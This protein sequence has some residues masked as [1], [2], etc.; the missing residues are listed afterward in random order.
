MGLKFSNFGKA[1]IAS[2]PV[3]ATGRSF[4]VEPGKG[5]VFPALGAGDYFYGIFK[6]ASGNREIVKIEARSTDSFTIAVGG[7]GLDGTTPRTWAAGDYFVATLTNI[8]LQETL[9]NENL[10]ALGALVSSADKMPYFT[11]AGAAALAT[12][13]PFARALL[14]DADAAAMRATLGVPA[15]NQVI[16]AGTAMIF[17]QA[18]APTGW[19]K[20]A[21]A[22]LNHA[23]R[24]TGGAGAGSGGVQPFTAAFASRG[25]SGTVWDTTLTTAQMPVHA[26]PVPLLSWAMH[27]GNS[28]SWDTPLYNGSS[29]AWTNNSGGGGA[30]THGFSG[31]PID[32]RVQY[33]DFILARKD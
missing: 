26:H 9:A 29:S 13:T 27:A 30:H 8:G 33:L 1:A 4:T 7:R 23:I 16:P 2:A 31:T 14:D 32:M 20:D 3:G 10:R 12:L 18:A 17:F 24:I 25:V 5:I 11:G 28:G 6:D 19:T 22:G 21:N 15:S